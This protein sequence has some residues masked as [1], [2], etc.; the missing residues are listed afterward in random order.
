MIL[1]ELKEKILAK[2]N[3]DTVQLGEP[4]SDSEDE[5]CVRHPLLM[6]SHEVGYLSLDLRPQFK[7]IHV[8]QIKMDSPES[9]NLVPVFRELK[10]RY[11]WARTLV[12]MRISGAHQ[13]HFSY[14]LNR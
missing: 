10:R 13:G 5:N 3:E 12:G 7:E 9:H 6:N 8:D 14:P 2:I 11:P 4:S 1:K